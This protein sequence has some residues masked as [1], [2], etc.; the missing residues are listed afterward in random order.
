MPSA[1]AIPQVPA[2]VLAN[3]SQETGRL[4]ILPEGPKGFPSCEVRWYRGK[5]AL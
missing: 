5:Q 3:Q 2:P 4:V 1:K